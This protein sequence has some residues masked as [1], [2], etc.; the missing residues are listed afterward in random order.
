MKKSLCV[1]AVVLLGA[2][3]CQKLNV[4]GTAEVGMAQTKQVD[5]TAPAYKQDVRA[6]I[7]PEKA[8]ISAY[9]VKTADAEAVVSFLDRN[10]G[11]EPPASQV[12]AGKTYQPKDSRQDI[13]LEATIPSRTP[14]SLILCGGRNSQKVKYKVVA[15]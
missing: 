6:T 3:G 2:I 10:V 9:L 1:L 12:L 8:S 15:R 5:F 13:T 4:E 7:E 11:K 14:Y